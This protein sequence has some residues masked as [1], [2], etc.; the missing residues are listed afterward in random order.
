[1]TDKI[2]PAE[3]EITCFRA[4]MDGVQR[5][6]TDRIVPEH[7][8]PPPHPIQTW[9]DEA[10]VM[11]V[12]LDHPY[13]PEELQPGDAI[14]FNRPGIQNAVLRKLRRG[15]YRIGAEIDLHGM[16]AA[17]ARD[18]LIRFL[19]HA[20]HSASR[21]VRIIHGKGH[22]SSNHGPVLK[23]LVCRWLSKRDDVLAFSSARP[24]DGGTGALYVLL[25]RK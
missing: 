3:D 2:I 6:E 5:I 8:K 16:S 9:K 17:M 24:A 14:C 20:Q 18:A 25:K 11:E 10:K 12:I 15:H 13:N 4:S 19:E 23:P 1:M 22:R 7:P 21:C